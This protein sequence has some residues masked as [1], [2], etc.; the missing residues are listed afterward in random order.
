M[1]NKV[2][3]TQ[4][5]SQITDN[6]SDEDFLCDQ[7]EM[8]DL[9]ESFGAGSQVE[10][11]LSEFRKNIPTHQNIVYNQLTQDS[12]DYNQI[13]VDKTSSFYTQ[14]KP[15]FEEMV[16]SIG[17][18][19]DCD[20]CKDTIE[21]VTFSLLNKKRKPLLL[22]KANDNDSNNDTNGIEEMTFLGEHVNGKRKVLKR[23]PYKFERFKPNKKPKL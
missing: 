12:I 10:S 18:Q 3:I 19:K 2:S 1:S 22:N 7:S 5:L 9:V 14:L 20:L 23:T 11:K 17:S 6:N 15:V 21:K 8:D 13:S 4:S 16:S